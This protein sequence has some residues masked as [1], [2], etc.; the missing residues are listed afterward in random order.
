MATSS[1][2]FPSSPFTH[3]VSEKLTKGNQA[4]WR[5]TVLSAIR[6]AQMQKYLNVDHPVPPMELEITDSNGKTKKKTPNPEFQTWYAQ[7]QVFSYLLTMLP[8]EMAIQVA[9]CHTS[10]ELWNTVQGM[11]SSQTRAMTVNVRIALANLQKGNSITDYVGKIRT[12]CDELIAVGKR[13]D[14][15]DVVS[16]ILAGLEEDFDP[17]VSAMCF[18]WSQSPCQ[19]CTRSS[20]AS[21]HG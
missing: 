9:T 18:E 14:E 13:V 15:E 6:G 20:L 10:A 4:L 21:R 11:L 19:S 5:A 12:L 17:V 3:V 7:K 16:H 2:T 8:R 1:N